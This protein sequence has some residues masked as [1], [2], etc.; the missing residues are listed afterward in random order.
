MGNSVVWIR[1]RFVQAITSIFVLLAHTILGWAIGFDLNFGTNGR[2][3][4]RLSA[5]NNASAQSRKVFVGSL[6]SLFVVA[7]YSKQGTNGRTSGFGIV[8]LNSLGGHDLSYGVNGKALIWSPDFSEDLLRSVMDSAGR[9]LILSRRGNQRDLKRFNVNGTVDTSFQPQLPLE[10]DLGLN[11]H[12]LDTGANGKIYLLLAGPGGRKLLRLNLDGTRDASFG[13]D[14]IRSMDLARLGSVVT[15]SGL[16]ETA[17]SKLILTGRSTLPNSFFA[18][19]FNNDG[20]IDMAYGRQGVLWGGIEHWAG[21]KAATSRILGDGCIFLAGYE[22]FYQDQTTVI[23]KIGSRGRPD[24]SFGRNGKVSSYFDPASSIEDV[25]ITPEQKIY[26]VGTGGATDFLPV[27][28]R[29]FV[30]RYSQ[31]G[32]QEALF[33][34]DFNFDRNATVQSIARHTDG[35]VII[36]GSSAISPPSQPTYGNEIAVAKLDH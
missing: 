25:V 32:Q 33:Q 2:T 31:V 26:A 9:I 21:G 1:K 22:G 10:S 5:D 19:R 4:I 23:F 27:R 12:F 29:V 8:R 34:T 13:S 24:G 3:L 11:L 30:V 17:G 20:F 7:D 14:G 6:G 28:T 35:K 18:M 16:H 36:A 15:F